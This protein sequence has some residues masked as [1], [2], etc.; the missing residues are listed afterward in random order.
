MLGD[1]FIF[2]GQ[3]NIDIP[4]AYGHQVCDIFQWTA[5]RLLIALEL[6][7]TPAPPVAPTAHGYAY[8]HFQVHWGLPRAACSGP[9]C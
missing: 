8:A 4:E 1:V 7:L 3:S 9:H 5:R 2:S 6:L